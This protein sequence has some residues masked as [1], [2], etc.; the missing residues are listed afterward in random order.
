LFSIHPDPLPDA[1]LLGRYH[2]DD[3]AYTDCYATDIALPVSHAQYISAFYTTSVFKLERFILTWTVFKPSTDAQ[4]RQLAEG[5][6]DAFAAWTVEARTENQL[7]MCDFVSRTR[8]WLMVLPLE[9]GGTRLYFGSAIATVIDS[10]TGKPTL[11]LFFR[12]LLGFHKIYSVVL[13]YA[14]KSRLEALYAKEMTS[15]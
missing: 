8:S 1:S 9:S 6:R 7:L 4:A 13:L 11:G 12:A 5:M 15:I 14:A 10:R 2:R 3:G